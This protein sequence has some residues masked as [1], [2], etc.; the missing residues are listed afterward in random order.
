MKLLNFILVTLM[1][2]LASCGSNTKPK[3]IEPRSE[4]F[5]SGELAKFIE[6]V[7]EPSELTFYEVDGAIKTQY[8]QLNVPVRMVK[9]GIKDVDP[10]DISF[11]SLLSVATVDLLDENGLKVQDLRIKSDD[12]FKLKKL[13]TQDEGDT[14]VLV[15]EGQFHNS[16]YAPKWFESTVGYTPGL[17][18]DIK[19]K[20]TTTSTSST[21]NDEAEEENDNI[22]SDET[23]S[24]LSSDKEFD[25]FLA[26]YEKFI[27]KYVA[28][29][30]KANDGDFDAISEALNLQEDAEEYEKKLEKIKGNL[31]MD[32]VVKFQKLQQKLLKAME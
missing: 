25:E 20:S 30:K 24:N 27:D 4:E 2:I 31:T 17:T 5:E 28:L 13:L 10:Y 6:V 22:A 18:A 29:M 11:I 16:D 1:L 32:Q 21:D 12:M 14:E 26:S 9:D 19:I 15:F 23:E 8:I 3:T 7:S